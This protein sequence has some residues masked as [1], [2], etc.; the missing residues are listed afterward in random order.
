MSKCQKHN[1]EIGDLVRFNSGNSIG[2]IYH[3]DRNKYFKRY[4]V[5]QINGKG[6][7]FVFSGMVETFD[8]M[9]PLSISSFRDGLSNEI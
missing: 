6:K 1:F 7:L 5:K 2:I 9:L 8:F 3:I 4:Y